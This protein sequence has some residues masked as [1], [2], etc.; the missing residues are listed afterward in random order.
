VSSKAHLE[1][2]ELAPEPAEKLAGFADFV[3]DRDV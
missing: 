1:G 2:L 3:V